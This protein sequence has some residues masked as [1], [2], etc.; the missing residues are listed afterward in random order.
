MEPAL[1]SYQNQTRTVE[2]R[3]EN[4][5][6]YNSWNINA[7]ILDKILANRIQLY[8]KWI[9][10]YDGVGLVS[11]VQKRL[12]IWESISISHL[13]TRQRR[14]ITQSC[15]SV[16]KS[17]W[18]SAIPTEHPPRKIGKMENFLNLIKSYKSSIANI[19]NGGKS[20]CCFFF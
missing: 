7:K 14:K 15:R 2:K 12:N 19:L 3:K 20:A 9:V 5:S 13:I 4:Y 8:K 17:I 1:V 11:G 10:Y 16:Q 6:Q 18:Q